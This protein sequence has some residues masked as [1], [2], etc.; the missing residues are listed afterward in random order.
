MDIPAYTRMS[1]PGMSVLTSNVI[2]FYRFYVFDVFCG[3][4]CVTGL[5]GKGFTVR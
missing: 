5:E 1:N 2:L 3:H 4:A